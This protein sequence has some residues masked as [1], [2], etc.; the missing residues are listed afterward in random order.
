MALDLETRL[1]GW[2]DIATYPPGAT[3]GPRVMR[4]YELVWMIEGDA[5]YFHDD[6]E[7]AAPQGSVVLC[8]P[9]ITDSFRWDPARRTRH[10]YVHFH[11]D[12][13][14]PAWPSPA[15][16]PVVRAFTDAHIVPPMFRHLLAWHERGDPTLVQL[17]LNH[18]LA[19]FVT[20]EATTAD[21][22]HDALPDPVERAM[23]F[24]YTALD[25][26]LA[27]PIEFDA[28]VEAS[29]VTGPHLC[30][31]FKSATGHSPAETV[32]LARLDRSLELVVRSNF[33]VKQIA[34]TCGFATPFHFTRLFTRAFGAAPAVLRKRIEAGQSPPLSRL[35]KYW[36]GTHRVSGETPKNQ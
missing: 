30:R 14:P 24:L 7:V 35:L 29:C 20:G 11:V 18:L 19:T 33:S 25:R 28:L 32:R 8:R 27:A 1:G 9:G 16:W 6:H 17:T 10:A 5:Q 13:Y 2:T 12:R 23:T 26:N 15:Q 31:L 34:A 22:P 36:N 4:E 3:F 21:V